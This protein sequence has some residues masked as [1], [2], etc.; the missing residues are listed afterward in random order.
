MRI[1]LC[2]KST[3]MFYKEAGQWTAQRELAENFGTSPKAILYAR[4]NGL[5]HVDVFWDFDDE[6]YNVSL[7]IA[8]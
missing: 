1:L 3:G 8:A 2:D 6:E 7:P 4:E 5:K